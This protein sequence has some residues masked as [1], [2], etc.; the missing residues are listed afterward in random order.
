MDTEVDFSSSVSEYCASDNVSRT[1]RR[2]RRSGGIRK[3]GLGIVQVVVVFGYSLILI[4]IISSTTDIATWDEEVHERAKKPPRAD[5]FV[6]VHHHDAATD[7]GDVGGAT[8]C[9]VGHGL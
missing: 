2:V 7:V 6:A 9:W 1:R 5:L 4:M 8:D 3:P